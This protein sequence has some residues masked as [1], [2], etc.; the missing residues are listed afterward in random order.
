[1]PV[2]DVK[3]LDAYVFRVHQVFNLHVIS[4]FV[5]PAQAGIQWHSVDGCSSHWTPVCAGVTESGDSCFELFKT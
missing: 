4:H 2:I 5:I 3:S 1:M